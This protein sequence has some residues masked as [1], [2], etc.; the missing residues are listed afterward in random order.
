M[1]LENST[2]AQIENAK[3][4]AVYI[5]GVKVERARIDRIT[6]ARV[7]SFVV[8]TAFEDKDV[9]ATMRTE[10][11]G[12]RNIRYCCHE[13]G[14]DMKAGDFTW[15][16]DALEF[17]GDPGDEDGRGVQLNDYAAKSFMANMDDEVEDECA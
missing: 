12:S 6:G 9:T 2:D 15:S 10:L 1:S 5:R 16:S 11:D 13:Y 4:H 8:G 7:F 3:V 14:V 17:S